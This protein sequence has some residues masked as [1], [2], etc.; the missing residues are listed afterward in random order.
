MYYNY[1]IQVFD[2]SVDQI[3]SLLQDPDINKGIYLQT[4]N[5]RVLL[6]LRTVLFAQVLTVLRSEQF[7]RHSTK[8]KEG[9][10]FSPPLQER[11]SALSLY[12]HTIC[13]HSRV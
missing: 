12:M 11:Y 8:C 1:G 7:Q 4:G 9:G 3:F 10:G 13:K 2:L 5:L 6:T